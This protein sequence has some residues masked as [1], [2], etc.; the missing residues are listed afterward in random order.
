MALR[1]FRQLYS[2]DTLD[3]R[4]VVPATATPKEALRDAE[5]DPAGPLPTQHRSSRHTGAESEV[6]PSRWN[7]T[8]F[9]IY[10]LS[11]SASIF[12]MFKL[13]LDVSKKSHPTYP[14]YSQ[15][16]ED[17]WIPG[18]KVDNVDSQ[19]SS[20][21]RNIPALGALV[22]LHPLLRKAYDSF[23]RA[24]TYTQ[25]RPSAGNTALTMGLTPAAAADARLDQ[26]VSF[27]VVFGCIL[28]TVLHGFSVFKI[29]AILYA[30]YCIA[31]KLPRQYV[32]AASWTFA[33]GTLFANEFTTG[34]Q[35]ASIFGLFLPATVSK[36]GR[37]ATNF[38]HTL[39]SYG[40]LMSRWEVLFKFTILRL[41]SFNLDYYW[42]LNARTGSTLEKQLDPSNLSERDRVTISANPTDYTFRNY[43]AYAIYS[44]LYLAG[45]IVTFNDWISQ[46]R[47]RPH[48]IT[49]RRTTMYAIRFIV[50]L[51]TME[52]MI[53]YMYM[54]AIFHQKPDW[55]QYTPAQ[56][57][58]LGF[59]NLKH[60]WLKLLIPWR[61][62]RLWA[63]VDGIDPPENM[64]RCMSD[65]YSV[66]QFWRGW[67]RSFNKWSLRYLY[68]P[69]G[70]S[71]LPGT[72]G[73]ARA[74]FSYL[75]VFTFIAV[76]H[77]IQLRLLMWGWLV[78]LF[79]L[80]E[81]LAAYV[82]PA[83]TWRHRPD[84]Y[85]WLCG[86]GAVGEILMLMTANLVGFALGL[87]GLDGLVK[88]ILGTWEG[89][90]FFWTACFALFT[91]A[92]FMFEWRENEKRRGIKMK[93]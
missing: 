5:L 24:S 42:C 20:F 21:R 47:H 11:I 85:R 4:F 53:H 9:Y 76:W 73:K 51:L 2:L 83:R 72:W 43:F 38:G 28:L 33:V 66:M 78:T 7:T 88:S 60:I 10:Y 30:N 25:A 57:S 44:P 70:G 82:F 34:F 37:P 31:T 35:Y 40:G 90:V 61:F 32:P 41:V 84:A 92:Q 19:Y 67:H 18:R 26:R 52:I 16:L 79:V 56:L 93:C 81:I 69:L 6:H 22:L 36:N 3:T 39:D 55:S 48:S 64:V 77:D 75:V 91:G 50:V 12:I 49:P 74:V 17:G 86:V 87:D 58:M 27:D 89:Q 14:Q 62:F 80:P 8:E 59:F 68:I 1:F 45:P 13:V 46:Q 54:V 15:L 63:L 71:A 29:A 23:W 65:N